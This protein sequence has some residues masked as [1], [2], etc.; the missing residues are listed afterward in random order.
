MRACVCACVR[1]RMHVCVCVRA[2]VHVCAYVLVSV[3]ACIPVPVCVC[4]RACMRVCV[5]VR[6]RAR[7]PRGH[8]IGVLLTVRAESL[9]HRKSMGKIIANT[10]AID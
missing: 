1:V 6:T 8:L 5:C 7:P 2:Y 10:L 9:P 3:C 4:L